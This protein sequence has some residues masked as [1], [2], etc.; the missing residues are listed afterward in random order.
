MSPLDMALAVIAAV[1]AVSGFVYGRGRERARQRREREAA[2]DEASQIL[3]RAKGDAES[4]KEAALLAGKE[5]A[6]R[7]REAWE[8]EEDR[9]REEVER[10]ER[11]HDERSEFLDK[12][13]DNLSERT[14]SDSVTILR[15]GILS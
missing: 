10:L 8:K 3:K 6:F 2:K 11:R 5:E 13:L 9:R 7:I 15:K 4:T 14:R 1:L 12:K